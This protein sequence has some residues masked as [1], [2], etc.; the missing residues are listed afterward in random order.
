MRSRKAASAAGTFECLDLHTRKTLSDVLPRGYLRGFEFAP[1]SKSFYYV[2]E[3]MVSKRPFYRAAYH[4][5]LGAA[6]SED[7]EIFLR[8]EQRKTSTLPDIGRVASGFSC[9]SVSGK[10]AHRFLP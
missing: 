4:H 1:D 9:V 5:L 2:H 6:F 7:R 10:D 3:S 8:R